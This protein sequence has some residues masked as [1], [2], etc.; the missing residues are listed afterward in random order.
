M[1]KGEAEKC[2][3]IGK[4]YLKMGEYSRAVKFFDKSLKLYPLPGVEGMRDRAAAGGNNTSSNGSSATSSSNREGLKQRKSSTTPDPT[5][6]PR[7]YTPEQIQ[8]VKKIKSCKT[9]YEVLNVR[10]DADENAIK[11]AYRKVRI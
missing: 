6:T 11:K 7:N 4:K 1:N 2:K 3:E 8:V 5:P 10:K 9:H